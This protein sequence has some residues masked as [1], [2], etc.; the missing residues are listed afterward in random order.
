MSVALIA[1]TGAVEIAVHGWDVSRATRADRPI[2]CELARDMWEIC[3][4]LTVDTDQHRLFAPAVTPPP[5][6]SLGDQLVALLGRKP[7][8][9]SIPSD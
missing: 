9:N 3:R 2:P 1:A 4:S 8:T 6:A 7:A 5:A